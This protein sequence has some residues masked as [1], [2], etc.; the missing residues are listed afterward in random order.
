MEAATLRRKI[1]NRK[2]TI[3]GKGLD[4][5]DPKDLTLSEQKNAATC[6]RF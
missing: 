2:L 1:K 3:L 5:L 6:K 4:V